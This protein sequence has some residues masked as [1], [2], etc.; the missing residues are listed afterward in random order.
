MLPGPVFTFELMTT[1]RRGRF[2]LA[3]ALYA[4]VL[5]V[6]LWNVQ[7]A[8]RSET[9]GELSHSQVKWFAFSAFCGIAIGQELLVLA[10]TPALVAGVIADEKKRKTL[11]YLLASQLSSAE[12][13]VGKLLGRM[14]YVVVLLGVSLPIL[15]LL[16]LL[17][18]IDP[19]L[20]LLACGATLSTAWF[21]ASLSIWVSTI[22]RRPREALFIALG[23]EGLW[24]CLLPAT[25]TVSLS[26]WPAIDGAVRWLGEWAGASSPVEV[27]WQLSWRALRG[28]VSRQ[29]AV[30][31]VAWMIVVQASLGLVFAIL[32]A[33]QLRPIFRRQSE[34]VEVRDRRGL[35][36]ILRSWLLGRQPA[37]GEHPLLWKELHTCGARGFTWL[38]GFLLTV[39]GGGFLAYYTVW[40]G[41]MASVEWWDQGYGLQFGNFRYA[42]D[43]FRFFLRMVMP[44]LYL[45]GILKVAGMAAGSITS[46]HEAD[47]WV[48]MT[49]TVLTGRE[50]IFAKLVGA[51]RRGR[52]L[53]E[54]IIALAVAGVV[55]GVL[56]VLSIPALMVGLSIYGWFAAALGLWVSLQ[57]R[58]TWRA[59]FLTVACLLLINILGQGVLGVVTP[60]GSTPLL[61]P[62]FTP[63]EVNQLAFDRGFFGFLAATGWP[64]SCA[65]GILT[66]ALPGRL[67][68]TS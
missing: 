28:G 50:I 19:L 45:A 58:S 31:L 6:I 57:F 53:A 60:Y 20:V 54:V 26:Q 38:L 39:I 10:L 40:Y 2:Y 46:E 23:L 41:A 12:I 61:W 17:G 48:S 29:P 56:H 43:N 34:G 63:H 5:F 64:R 13:V 25:R 7:S 32:A 16:V 37:L 18:G 24:L 44:L 51:L 9:G 52:Q 67:F 3:R 49:S 14:L 35:R 66:A 27:V 15:S 21:L 1:A 68:S 33:L 65:S 8:W 36:S 42:R 47:T 30:D 22:A 11:H 62:G 4:A 59:Q 55:L